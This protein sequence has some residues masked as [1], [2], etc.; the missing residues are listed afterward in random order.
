M[1]SNSALVSVGLEAPPLAE[2]GVSA[3]DANVPRDWPH[4]KA[5]AVHSD[6]GMVVTDSTIATQVGRDI[7][8]RQGN[9]FDAAVAVAFALAVAYPTAGNLGGGGFAVTWSRGEAH[10]LDFREVAPRAARRDMFVNAPTLNQGASTKPAESQS[11]VGIRSVA[12]PGSVA[13][14]WEL[15]QRLGSRRLTWAELLQP[16]VGLARSGFIVDAEFA[17]SIEHAAAQLRRSPASLALFFPEGGAKLKDSRFRNPDLAVVLERIA[18]NGR[19]GFYRG[20]TAK[21]IVAQMRHDHG[22]ITQADLD[23]Y[24]AKW[25]EPLQFTYRAMHVTAMPP[26]SSGGVTLA[27]IC[28][29]LEAYDLQQLGFQSSASLHLVF[30]SMRRAFAARN[31]KLGDP[32]FV[33]M[34]LDELLGSAWAAAQRS[35]IQADRATPS[36]AIESA[37][38]T[39][40]TGMHT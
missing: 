28:H 14:L 11:R 10:A 16:A 1:P 5:V 36:T 27:M 40:T 35:T 33:S 24:V 4:R 26:P 23:S 18:E 34:P 39:Q 3:L 21:A 20:A 22:L 15:Y 31:A 6:Q 9:A 13:G 29:I 19:E 32:D 38:T 30:E 25:R 8:A 12:V 2:G 7:L 37:T 17:R